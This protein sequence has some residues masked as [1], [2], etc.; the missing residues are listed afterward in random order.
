MKKKHELKMERPRIYDK[1]FYNNFQ[2]V[3]VDFMEKKHNKKARKIP[4]V[5]ISRRL[6]DEYPMVDVILADKVN[7][8][9][10]RN[11]LDS[12]SDMLGL[13]Q[14]KE[15]TIA[16]SFMKHYW[17]IPIKKDEALKEVDK[18]TIQEYI[19]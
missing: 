5:V 13:F 6:R 16:L 8:Q 12:I 14:E 19:S 11:I 9:Q 10:K 18:K 1:G 2:V 4:C 17:E 7:M 15:Y 3:H